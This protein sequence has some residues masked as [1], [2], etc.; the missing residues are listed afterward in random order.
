MYLGPSVM[1]G[2]FSG[3]ASDFVFHFSQYPDAHG[4]T[5][6]VYDLAEQMMF[7]DDPTASKADP[8]LMNPRARPLASVHRPRAAVAKGP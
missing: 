7:L 6:A 1:Q 2:V 3:S 5:A 8:V 4:L